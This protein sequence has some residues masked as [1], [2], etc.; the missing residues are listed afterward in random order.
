M[1]AWLESSK[2]ALHFLH[3]ALR[4]PLS[5]YATLCF[6]REAEVA[7]VVKV[8]HIHLVDSAVRTDPEA[9]AVEHELQVRVSGKG[10]TGHVEAVCGQ[11]VG[12]LDLLP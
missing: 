7:R 10:C 2:P 1:D 6:N 12:R 4:V 8:R 9:A 3:V 11:W 5:S